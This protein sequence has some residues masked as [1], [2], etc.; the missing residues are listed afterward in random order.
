MHKRGQVAI[1]LVVGLFFLLLSAFFLFLSRMNATSINNLSEDSFVS[2][3]GFIDSCLQNV[4]EKG[5]KYIGRHGGYFDLPASSEPVL[6]IPYYYVNEEIIAPTLEEIQR[7]Y[8]QYINVMLPLCLQNFKPL[9]DLGYSIETQNISTIVVFGQ[10]KALIDVYYPVTMAK[11]DRVKTLEHFSKEYPL[12]FIKLY[13]YIFGLLQTQ[14]L[15]PDAVPSDYLILQSAYLIKTSMGQNGVVLFDIIDNTT[16]I[17][18]EPYHFVFLFDYAWNTSSPLIESIDPVTIKVGEP[19]EY[20]VSAEG[21]GLEYSVSSV[22]EISPS[23]LLH[24]TPQDDDLGNHTVSITVTD[25]KKNTAST[26][27]DIEVIR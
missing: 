7:Q 21:E 19:W 8:A 25:A 3:G 5:L 26:L 10:E 15:E 27:L 6:G 20:Q 1:F 14:L 2:L 23:G 17:E 13:N 12:T 18:K 24:F 4:V 16:Y 11:S 22:V 9:T